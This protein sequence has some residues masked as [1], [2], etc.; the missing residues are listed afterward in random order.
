M[1]RA[2]SCLLTLSALLPALLQPASANSAPTRWDGSPGSEVLAVEENCPI[3]VTH[4]DLSFRITENIHYSLH[5]RV[6]AIYQME[7]PTAEAQPVQ[8]AFSL[9]ESIH[10]FDPDAVSVTADGKQIPFQLVWDG[11]SPDYVPETFDPNQTGTLYTFTLAEPPEDAD[12][13]LTLLSPT[14]FL[15][16]TYD[17]IRSYSGE[18]DGTSTLGTSTGATVWV[19]A[20]DGNLD[21]T[22]TGEYTVETEELPFAQHF[23]AYLDKRYEGRYTDHLDALTAYKYHQLEKEWANLP[24]VMA[25][26]PENYD[27]SDI[28][29]QFLYTVAFP[30][31]ETVEVAVAY[32]TRSDGVREGTADWQHTFTYLLSP[33][34]H[35]ASFG[36]LDL[37]VD[38]AE[39]GYPYVI[40]SSLPLE[41]QTDGSYAAHSDGLPAEDLSFTLYSAPEL[42][43]S[44]RITSS[45]GITTYT[46]AFFQFLA[47]PVLVIAA[48]VVLLVLRHR[49]KKANR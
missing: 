32:N 10:D 46:L 22:V 38:A 6:E 11:V 44:D 5:A 21:Y 14:G 47:V 17:G 48:V 49:R 43:L 34:Q 29:L 25:D 36:T 3:S 18:V 9:E 19:Y 16:V 23:R 31:H 4:E 1:K 8:M 37:T 41:E 28:P 26:W 12:N 45:L 40:S 35:W 42:S 27:Y 20:L 2:V 39:S 13:D 30:A 15:W 33:A 7:N 24:V